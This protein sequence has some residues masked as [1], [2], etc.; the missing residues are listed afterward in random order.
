[1]LMAKRLRK[2][3]MGTSGL[4]LKIF[5]MAVILDITIMDGMMK[6]WPAW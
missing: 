5:S 1:M 3:L 6:L 4:I 2:Q